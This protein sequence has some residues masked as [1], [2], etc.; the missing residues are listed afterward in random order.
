MLSNSNPKSKQDYFLE[1][2]KN[3]TVKLNSLTAPYN[4]LQTAK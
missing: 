2:E 3:S 4:F 1:S